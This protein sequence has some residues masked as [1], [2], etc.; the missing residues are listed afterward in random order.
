MDLIEVSSHAEAIEHAAQLKAANHWIEYEFLLMRSAS[1]DEIDEGCIHGNEN[2]PFYY[3]NLQGGMA[4]LELDRSVYTERANELVVVAEA[5]A[6][7][8]AEK[9]AAAERAARELRIREDDLATLAALKR[10]YPGQ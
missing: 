8:E 6:K 10:K 2:D 1:S 3:A 4:V 9:R 7:K 5:V